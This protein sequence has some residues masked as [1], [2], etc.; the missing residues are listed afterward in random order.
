[1]K[2]RSASNTLGLLG[3]GSLLLAGCGGGASGGGRGSQ[4][5]V[6]LTS[7]G[8]GQMLPHRVFE[9]DAAGQ[10]TS[11]LIDITVKKQLVENVTPLNPL[12]PPTE[13]PMRAVLPNGEAGNHFF[14]TVFRQ[15]IDIASV[16][17]ASTGAAVENNLTGA[18]K[19]FGVDPLSGATTDLRGRAFIGGFTYGSVDPN[20]ATKLRLEQWVGLDGDGKPI[21]LDVDG[22]FPGRGF[23][24]TQSTTGFAGAADL[25]SARTFVFVPDE[26]D[27]LLTHETFPTN[28]QVRM[29]MSTEVLGVNGNPLEQQAVA[30]T[31]VGADRVSPEVA[32]AGQFQTPS[33]VPGDGEFDVDPRTSIVVKLTEPVQIRTIGRFDDGTPPPL[34]ASI[35]LLFGPSTGRV[36]VPFN[37]DLPSVF[38]LTTVE[39]FPAYNFPGSGPAIGAAACGNFAQIDVVVNSPQF[40]DLKGNMNTLSP[41][42]FFTT[43]EGPG[44]V[45]APVAPDAIYVGRGGSEQAISVIDLNGFGAGPGNPTYDI[46]NPVREGNSNYP[47]N[48]NVTIQGSLLRPPLNPGDCTFNGGSA[49][50]FTLAKDSSLGDRLATSPLIDS[51]GDMALGHALDISF[52]NASPFGC[53]SGGGNICSQTALKIVQIGQGGA[54]TLAPITTSSFLIKTVTGAENLVSWS[55]HPNPPPLQFPPLCLSPFIGAVEPTS[56][57]TLLVSLLTN[58]L[59]PGDPFGDPRIGRP[60]T[61]LLSTEQNAFFNG[62]SPPQTNINLCLPF[63]YRQQIGQ[64][65]Y[66]VDRAAS[67]IVVLNSNRFTVIDRI[68]LPDPTSLAMSPD[69][70]YLA[71]TNQN[72]DIVSFIDTDP[73]SSSFHQV[74]RTT[75]VGRGPTGIAWESGNEDIFV[76][77]RT[78]NTVSIISAFSFAVRKTLRN[79]LNGPFEV[80]LTPR[81]TTHG[82]LRAVYFG[83][84]LN[85]DGSV[86]I[87]ESGPNGING[88][89]F[90]DIIGSPAFR[91]RN[92]KTMQVDIS[93]LNSAVWIVHEDQV[94]QLGN[95]T[96]RTGGAVSNMAISSATIGVIPLDPGFFTNPQL[97]DLEFRVL[98]SIGSDQLTGIPVDITFDDL[99]NQTALTN[100]STPYS[101]G[102]PLSING[103][104]IVKPSTFVIPTS[105]PQFMF[106]AVPNSNEGPGV[107]DVI[108]LS[109]GFSRFDTNPFAAGVQSIPVPGANR[110][111]NYMRQ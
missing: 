3:L 24:A 88:W 61:G 84:I 48:P 7:N 109:T 16:L 5:V 96:G 49:G 15:E 29:E 8:F 23:P 47:N 21:A 40:A 107:V 68:K 63:M 33:I 101:V 17:D 105:A 98:A 111:M 77:N 1:M 66:V 42:T 60:P 36:S 50:V 65:L 87:F 99:R 91:F 32:V 59:G 54:N 70:D 6:Q 35:S 25:V 52:N 28:L 89:G 104:S 93:N 69:L 4:M 97:R 90:D 9:A 75:R 19:V 26:D 81:Q 102:F 73:S 14:Y 41:S 45:N 11:R 83:Y 30:S 64:F 2:Q 12:L 100:Y 22:E 76:C 80:V 62:P 103:K 106:L 53:Q 10:P 13:W 74:V 78:E 39:L 55:P 18:I 51:V 56:T 95:P 57:D 46:A 92:P 38:D 82:F 67:E 86:A 31:T 85:S 58:L 110:L 27:D 20:D 94:D 79:Q 72:A 37:I 34:S 43:A 108:D 71:V 44:L